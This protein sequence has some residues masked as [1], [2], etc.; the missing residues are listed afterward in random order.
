MP[1]IILAS[2]SPR[3]RELLS[4]WLNRFETRPSNIVEDRF[5]GGTVEAYVQA[6]AQAKARR[7]AACVENGLVIAADTVVALD[8]VVLGKPNSAADARGMLSRLSGR[9]HR[10][11]T[12]ICL[13]R[14]PSDE[15]LGYEATEVKFA[16][17]TTDEIEWYVRT[18]ETEDKAGAYAIQGRGA[19][20]IERIEGDYFNVVG[21][22]IRLVY[23]LANEMG[24]DL[25][26]E[27]A[28]REG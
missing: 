8:D 23:R 2:G 20:L 12:G 14:T 10:V 4:H 9:W 3:R 24:V 6:I 7:V 28:H 19:F 25:K 17:L 21:L 13:L 27:T 16:P 26:R 18:G 22:P 1:K 15:V 11:L 5:S